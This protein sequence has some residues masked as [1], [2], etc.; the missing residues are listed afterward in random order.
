MMTLSIMTP[1]ILELITEAGSMERHGVNNV[2]ML[3]I[4]TQHHGIQHVKGQHNDNQHNGTSCHN[5][6]HDDTQHLDN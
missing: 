2:F 4:K 6:Y 1:N 5:T 3:R